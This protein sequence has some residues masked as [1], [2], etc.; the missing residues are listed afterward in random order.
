MDR[1]GCNVWKSKLV[2][3]AG[4]FFSVTLLMFK[5]EELVAKVGT[6]GALVS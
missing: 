6:S 4:E 5:G 3:K 1:R 2:F